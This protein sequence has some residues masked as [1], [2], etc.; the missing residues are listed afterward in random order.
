MILSNSSFSDISAY[1]ARNEKCTYDRHNMHTHTS[2]ELYCFL[3][4]KCVYHVE[5]SAYLLQPGD[6]LLMRPAEAHY[7]ETD[8]QYPYE[9]MYLNFDINILTPL[10]RENALMRP[11]FHR[12][13]GTRNLY[14]ASQLPS[15]SCRAYLRNMVRPGAERLAV[16]ANLIL[17]LQQICEAF[18]R[19]EDAPQPETVEYRIIRYINHNL[20]SALTIEDLCSRF[21]LSRTQLCSR[22]KKATASSVC[23]YV[24]VKRLLAARQ[25]IR[26][27]QKP[28]EIFAA[29]GYQDYA[30]F[31]RAYVRCFG[32]SPKQDRDGQCPLLL[33]NDWI[34]IG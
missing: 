29:C 23:R 31:Y 11:F 2:A 34:D 16:L 28:T 13:A 25:L 3:S 19:N 18:D 15:D 27:G 12:K 8:P 30:S 5:G 7:V 32:C 26:Q 33:E 9:R 1:H 20:G 14:R 10:D 17:L 4:G 21:F 22:F 6:I 24:A